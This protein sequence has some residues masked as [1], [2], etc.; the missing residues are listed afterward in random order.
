MSF[1]T[2]RYYRKYENFTNNWVSILLETYSYG[3]LRYLCPSIEPL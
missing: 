1:I 3:D 2:I